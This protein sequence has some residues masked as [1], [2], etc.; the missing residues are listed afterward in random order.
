[1]PKI[2][3]I[4]DELAEA[5]YFSSV[6]AT[7]EYYQIEESSK[8]KTAFRWKIG[9]YEFNRILFGLCNA[10]STFQRTMDNTFKGREKEFAIP[11]LD[12]VIIYSK[13]KDEHVMHVD[14]VLERLGDAGFSPNKSKCKFFREVMEIWGNIISNEKVKSDANKVESLNNFAMSTNIKELRS[15]LGLINYCA[16]L[17]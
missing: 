8:C 10:P 13:T 2:Y 16:D 11:Y 5:K 3:E 9:F 15:F 1:M 17:C 12:D 14:R 6:D 4:I 7:C